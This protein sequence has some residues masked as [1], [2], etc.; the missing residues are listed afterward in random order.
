MKVVLPTTGALFAAALLAVA[1]QLTQPLVAM[2]PPALVQQSLPFVTLAKNP[3]KPK[4]AADA[5][6]VDEVRRTQHSFRRL[7]RASRS[8]LSG[9]STL[10]SGLHRHYVFIFVPPLSAQ[11]SSKIRQYQK[12]FPAKAGDPVVLVSL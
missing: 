4:P 2:Q 10:T 7:G 8:A 12:A 5:A 6:P 9:H 11:V 3:V 1:P